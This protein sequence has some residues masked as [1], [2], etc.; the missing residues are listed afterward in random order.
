MDV[1]SARNSISMILTALAAFLYAF[2]LARKRPLAAAASS[3]S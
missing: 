3:R 1:Y 2:D